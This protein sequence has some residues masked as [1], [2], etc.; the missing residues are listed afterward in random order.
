MQYVIFSPSLLFSDIIVVHNERLAEA[1]IGNADIKCTLP[2]GSTYRR[3]QTTQ[4][5]LRG[6]DAE[7]HYG[8]MECCREG[9]SH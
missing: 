1:E 5:L 6:K 7:I 3:H 9:M 8:M 2:E 4:W